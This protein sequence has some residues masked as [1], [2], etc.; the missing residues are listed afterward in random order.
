M[1]TMEKLPKSPKQELMVTLAGPMVNVFIAFILYFTIPVKELM[2]L[3]FTE[4][5]DVL[6]SFSL[7][8]F[9]FNLFIVNITLVIFNLIPA[10]PLDGGR[11]L[12]ALLAIKIGRIKATQITSV[13]GQII[14]VILFLIGLLY[15]PILVFIALFIFLGA[16]GENQIVQHLEL[17]RGH[18]VEEAMMIN[19]TV[20]KPEDGLDLVANKIICGTENNFVVVKDGDVVGLLYHKDIID[21]SNKDLLVKDIMQTNFKTLHCDDDL[22]KAYTEIHSIKNSFLPVLENKKLV[23]AIDSTNLNEYILFQP[24]PV[25]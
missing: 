20:F 2:Q 21:N 6:S 10:F 16:Y 3:N 12:R 13:I 17:L 4:T 18:S 8:N 1:A 11:I 22:Q 9:L 14:A 15:N 5:F 7:Q 24:K 23:G 19:I 25:Y